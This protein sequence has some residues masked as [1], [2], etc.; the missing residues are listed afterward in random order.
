MEEKKQITN[1]SVCVR[2]VLKIKQ[3]QVWKNEK[4]IYFYF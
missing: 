3:N 4:K 2:K 1:N